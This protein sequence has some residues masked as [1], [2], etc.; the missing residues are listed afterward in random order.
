MFKLQTSSKQPQDSKFMYLASCTAILE[1]ALAGSSKPRRKRNTKHTLSSRRGHLVTA[2][3]ELVCSNFSQRRG[4]MRICYQP[5][6]DKTVFRKHNS[7]WEN[8]SCQHVIF[9][10]AGKSLGGKCCFYDFPVRK[11]R[12]E[13]AMVL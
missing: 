6:V 4:Y 9:V 5:S 3:P 2:L 1:A 8:M 7:A 13:I 10:G 12:A 11:E